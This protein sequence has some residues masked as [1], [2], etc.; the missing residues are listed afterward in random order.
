MAV[1][2][3]LAVHK[4][5]EGSSQEY[6]YRARNITLQKED[7][8]KEENHLTATFKQNGYPLLFILPSTP[9]EET[10]NEEPQEEEK[11]LVVTIPYVPGVSEW[12]RKACEKFDLKVVFKSGQAFHSL[13]T[14]VKDPLPV[15]GEASLAIR[16]PASVDAKMVGN[17]TQGYML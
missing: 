16:S 15:D 5:K 6:F 12:M 3:V 7:L 14:R 17:R 10:G 8:Q 4:C 2:D 1:H 13:L 9:P 11:L